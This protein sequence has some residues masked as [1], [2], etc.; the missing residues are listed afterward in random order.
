MANRCTPATQQET[1]A[2]PWLLSTFDT[3]WNNPVT[4]LNDS[5]LGYSNYA[6]DTGV[7]N[8]YSV[9]LPIGSPS[10]YNQGMLVN[11][12][13]A[14]T[15]TGASSLT[16]S[17]LGAKTIVTLGG[18]ALVAG[19]IVANVA[20]TVFFDGTNFRLVDTGAGPVVYATDTGAVN[21]YVLA[22]STAVSNSNSLIVMT[23]A[24]TNTG[25]STLNLN[26]LGTKPIVTAANVALVPGQIWA[27]IPVG[28]MYDGTSYRIVF[29]GSYSKTGQFSAINGNF[30]QDCTGGAS[31]AVN[32]TSTT[33][34]G[35]RMTLSNASPGL[36][37]QWVHQNL[38]G[39]SVVI[40]M[41]VSDPS[42]TG[43]AVHGYS[44][45]GVDQRLDG[46][47]TVTVT[48]GHSAVFLGAYNTAA[49]AVQGILMF[50]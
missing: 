20:C 45:V 40:G 36:D 10:A 6:A 39:G 48:T 25:A 41:N 14:N 38:S 4:S 7:A 27:A 50:S 23:P 37:I 47:N 17:P 19:A 2:P 5:S 15:N 49:A 16:V 31:I 29:N 24:N 30:T 44:T 13:P 18:A 32:S 9:A 34:A 8:A 22:A 12:L 42:G 11:F 33:T 28:M 1:L 46:S 3:N 43:F 35:V 26:G 21:A